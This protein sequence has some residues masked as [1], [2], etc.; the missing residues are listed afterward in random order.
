MWGGAL[1][2]YF[3]HHS[4]QSWF[5]P[6]LCPSSK[7]L[8]AFGNGTRRKRLQAAGLLISNSQFQPAV[9]AGKAHLGARRA[10]MPA[11]VAQSFCHHL[12]SFGG[13][14]VIYTDFTVAQNLHRNAREGRKS[15]CEPLY[16]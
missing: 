6:D 15:Y 3:Y 9:A 16:R 13:K 7:S 1:Q 11:N 12:E 2:G 5:A 10:G 14:T 4:R 8:G